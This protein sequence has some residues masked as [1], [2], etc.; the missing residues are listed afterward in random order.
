MKELESLSRVL[1][2][3]RELLELL[4]FKQEEEHLVLASGRGR[5]LAHATREVEVVLGQIRAAEVARA[6]ETDAAASALGLGPGPSL[7]E[8]ADAAPAPWSDL[9]HDH[10]RAFMTLTQEIQAVAGDNRDLVTAGA[11]AARE[12]LRAMDAGTTGGAPST[13]GRDGQ[14]E[15]SRQARLL[16]E[17]L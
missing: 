8:L 15:T 14:L 16:D 11:R 9:L 17:A 6:A 2:A 13:Y 7:R 1:W 3:E 10:R 5:W 12:A 4:L